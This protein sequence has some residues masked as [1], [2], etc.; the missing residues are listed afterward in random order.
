MGE[1]ICGK[2]T[3]E[4]KEVKTRGSV[5]QTFGIRASLATFFFHCHQSIRRQSTDLLV[6][7]QVNLLGDGGLT[8]CLP[9]TRFA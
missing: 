9:D 8:D 1:E 5:S 6:L 4:H 7:F 3:L 2:R